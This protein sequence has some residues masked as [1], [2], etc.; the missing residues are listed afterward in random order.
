MMRGFDS[1]ESMNGDEL[2][3]KRKKGSK[4]F[5][6]GAA[7]IGVMFFL[8]GMLIGFFG[9]ESE[10]APSPATTKPEVLDP[11][12]LIIQNVDVN[13]L[14]TLL[15]N[16]SSKARMAGTESGSEL[17]NMI[18]DMWAS[19]GLDNVHLSTYKVLLSFPNQSDPNKVE[20][21]NKTTGKIV[22]TSNSFEP[23]LT[24]EDQNKSFISYNAF[25]PAGTVLGSIVYVNYGTVEDFQYLTQNL[26]MDLSK[27]I[28][29]ARYGIISAS[30]KVYNAEQYNASAIVLYSD[31]ADVNRDSERQSSESAYPNSW[32]LPKGGI[33]RDTVNYDYG[34]PDTPGY[35]STN[36][37]LPIDPS[38]RALTKIPCQPV[39]YSDAL[40]LL[41][42]LSGSVSPEHWHG[43]LPIEY[44]IGPG[45]ENNSEIEVKVTVN[46]YLDKRVIKNVIGMIKGSEEPDRYIIL[47]SH[48]DA[49]V[50]GTVDPQS[51]NAALS[52]A[53]EIFGHL[54]AKGFRPRRTVMFCSWDA[55]EFGFIGSTEWVEENLELI[56]ERSVAYLNV[57]SLV[58]GNFSLKAVS[59][60][61]LQDAMYTVAHQVPSPTK[62]VSTLYDLWLAQSKLYSSNEKEPSVSYS[63][64][65]GSDHEVFYQRAGVSCADLSFN[66]DFRK[67]PI[68]TYP[69]HHSA[70]DNYFSY[71]HFNDPGLKYSKAVTQFWVLLAN[72]LANAP[73]LPFKV[74]RFSAA[75]ENF[76]TDLVHNYKEI[77]GQNNVQYDQLISAAKNFTE[78]TICFEKT[79]LSEKEL[80]KKPLKLRMYNDQIMQTERAFLIQQGLPSKP[81]SKNIVFTQSNSEPS[82]EKS[83]FPGISTTMYNIKNGKSQWDQLKH[84]IYL[85]T[86]CL[87]SA[88][89]QLS[90]PGTCN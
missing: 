11:T 62:N 8:V 73:L 79:L 38:K 42:N 47:G 69:L 84:Q 82:N 65:S 18:R 7:V 80:N 25:S 61:L 83:F 77:W 39:S 54:L 74:T 68:T 66:F 59:S 35:P 31:P 12:Q 16:F 33:Q 75:L 2:L 72:Y 32:W 52:Q 81:F 10:H 14:Q 90:L 86:L 70:Y 3:V 15:K 17:A 58:E 29:I 45:Y 51:G 1:I 63:L 24:T 44:R 13:F 37:N 76:I 5:V 30:K 88:A 40:I 78:A 22:F 50:Y 34:D 48:H 20:L 4:K 28:V 57:H 64:W 67:Y 36:Y 53:V 6:I 41:S 9:H 71:E 43:A 89:T 49:W 23:G 26:S 56:S 87:Q 27:K 21:V 19:S 55:S 85:A 60:P 46:N